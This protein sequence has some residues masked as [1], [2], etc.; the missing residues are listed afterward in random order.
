GTCVLWGCIPAK[1]LLESAA[2]ATK[3]KHAAEHGITLG[4]VK[5]DF[6]PAMNRSRVKGL[7]QVGLE[8]NKTTVLSSDDVLVLEKAP[9]TMAVVGAGAVGCEFADVFS[10]FGTQVTLLEV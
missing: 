1:S 2:L 10:A 3:L 8:L 4:E 9:K 7:P 6:Q 5:L